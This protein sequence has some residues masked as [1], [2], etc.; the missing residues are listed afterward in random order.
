MFRFVCCLQ[1]ANSRKANLAEV[2]SGEEIQ[3]AAFPSLESRR[4]C[5]TTAGEPFLLCNL[6]MN[7]SHPTWKQLLRHIFPTEKEKK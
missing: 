5:L 3:S 2:E 7:P 6:K 1:S 4:L